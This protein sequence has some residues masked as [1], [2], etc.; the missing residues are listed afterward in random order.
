MI[1]STSLD[2]LK[3]EA[4]YLS[5]LQH[6]RIVRFFGLCEDN[7][8]VYIVTEFCPH[9]LTDLMQ[10][11][12]VEEHD[13]DL[14]ALSLRIAMDV[15]EAMIFMHS[16]GYLHRDLKP[17]NILLDD[18]WRVKLCDFGVTKLVSESNRLTMTGQIGTAAYMP[19]EVMKG[20]RVV[21]DPSV[22]VYSFAVLLW[23]LCS[24]KLPYFGLNQYQII[25]M[26]V[27]KQLRPEA[28]PEWD[29]SLISIIESCWAQD[30][31]LRPPFHSILERLHLLDGQK[32]FPFRQ[33]E[34]DLSVASEPTRRS[35][36]Q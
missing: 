13:L 26:V 4:K 16:R 18:E 30:P 12:L 14:S 28:D 6:P 23:A 33:R 24:R 36:D 9:V 32:S 20:E 5:R 7:Q 25:K 11:Q 29:P 31:S 2:E 27:D 22:D 8:H 34:R 21:C 10:E 1:D 17:E 15:C 19:P 3:I 35:F